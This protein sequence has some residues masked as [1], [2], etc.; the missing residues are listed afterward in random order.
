MFSVWWKLVSSVFCMSA[1]IL[2][3]T[4][5]TPPTVTH[6]F[7]FCFSPFLFSLSY[8]YV[9]RLFL[10]RFTLRDHTVSIHTLYVTLHT[11]YYL[12]TI[13]AI[14]LVSV[15]MPCHQI[16]EYW[17]INWLIIIIPC[18]QCFQ[19][20]YLCFGFAP[21]VDG[22]GGFIPDL[23]TTLRENLGADTVPLMSGICR[24]DGALFTLVCKSLRHVSG[25]KSIN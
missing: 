12:Q 4:H 2:C 18:T 10:N 19:P 16:N 22:P 7:S 25:R 5:W 24:D 21:I 17:L 14:A 11:M 9:A 3:G 20:G 15:V 23:P 8:M 1:F 13:I 6:I